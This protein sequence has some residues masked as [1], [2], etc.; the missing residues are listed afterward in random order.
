MKGNLERTLAFLDFCVDIAKPVWIR[1]VMVPGIT[2][3]T[4]Q[5]MLLG[6]V[7]DEG[8]RRSVIKRIELLPFHRMADHK[9]DKMGW[10][11][12][13]ADTPAADPNEVAALGQLLA[14]RGFPV[15]AASVPDTPTNL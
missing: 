11:F 13:L 9:Y 8:D 6:D 14:D 7:L 10:K 1:Q 2:L 4:E 12:P 5:V 3:S 15:P